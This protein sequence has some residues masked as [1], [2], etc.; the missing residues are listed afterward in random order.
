[1][2]IPWG[3]LVYHTVRLAAALL[4]AQDCLQASAIARAVTGEIRATGRVAHALRSAAD[5]AWVAL[6]ALETAQG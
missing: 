2:F 3:T 1:M 4:H 6:R 5:P